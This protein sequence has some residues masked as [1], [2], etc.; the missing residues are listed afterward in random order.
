MKNMF[1]LKKLLRTVTFLSFYFFIANYS[2]SQTCGFTLQQDSGC[3]PLPILA[4]ATDTAATPP[5]VSRSWCLTTCSGATVFCPQPG[6]NPSF[7][8]VP[9]QAGCYTLTMISTNQSGQ[10]CTFAYP[11]ILVSDTPIVINPQVGPSPFCAPQTVTLNMT[12]SAGCGSIEETQIQWGCG[13]IDQC[14]GFCP[15]ATHL[16][17][18]TCNPICYSVNVVLRNSCGCVGTKR[19][20]NGVCVLPKP[21]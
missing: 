21:V 9:L 2:Y 17:S 13:N 19:I 1:D 5:V 15:T 7:S 3:I 4:T 12:A 6:P 11:N 14:V 16:Y 8:F 10:T 20:T 18:G